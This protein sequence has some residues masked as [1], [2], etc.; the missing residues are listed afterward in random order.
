MRIVYVTQGYP[1]ER[2]G[3]VEVYLKGLARE[4][5]K[6]HEVH[7]FSRGVKSGMRHGEVYETDEAGVHITRVYVDLRQ[8]SEFRDVYMRAWVE[9]LFHEYLMRLEPDLVHIQHLGGLSLGMIRT[10]RDLDLPV[11]MTLS[12]HQPHCPLGQRIRGDKRVCKKIN[13][14]ECLE[15]VKPQCA[16]L[17]GRSAKLVAYLMG[18]AHGKD[19]LRGMHEDISGH[20]EEVARFIM[21]SESHRRIMI[22]VGVPGD[23]SEVQP[24]GLDLSAF[25][26]VPP[27]PS[28]E[29]V[30]KFAYLGTLIPSKG[31]EDVI[32][33]FKKMKTPGCSLHV[34]GEAVPYHGMVDYDKRLAELARSADVSFYGAYQPED[35]P[36]V[37]SRIDAVVMPSRWYE[38][39][40]IT[41]REA[42]RA[43]RPVIVSDIGAFSEAVEDTVNGLKFPPGDVF[44]LADAMDRL[45]SDPGLAERLAAQGGP[46]ESLPDHAKKL[47]EIYSELCE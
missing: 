46:I 19:L 34:Y 23:R 43:G 40:G 20:F 39:Y 32:R 26:E 8:V 24:Y 5:S 2:V 12:D 4:M 45:A 15:C 10:A 35:L 11:V 28:G 16:G 7:I 14:D 22:E 1:P 17:P 6:S 25:E 33:A 27:R 36:R 18:K 29:P 3:G 41:I 9:G 42:F 37:L 47:L 30:R 38:S 13:L 31:V 44:A 21:P